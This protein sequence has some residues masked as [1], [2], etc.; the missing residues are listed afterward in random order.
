MIDG[1]FEWVRDEP[2]P[3]V[4]GIYRLDA[5]CIENLLIHEDAAVQLVIE[6]AA[7][8]EQEAQKRFDFG[9]WLASISGSLVELFVWFAVLNRVNP[10]EPT[11]GLGVGKIVSSAKKG[12]MPVL[13]LKKVKLLRNTIEKKAVD[14]VG[15]DVAYELY[16]DVS[17]RVAALS[18]P[19]DS[20]SGKDFLLPLFEYR[21][22]SC[23]RGRTRR[24]SL[25]IRLARHCD[26][27]RF[28]AVTTA[29]EKSV[30]MDF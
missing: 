18:R 15:R 14:A 16:R 28:V 21:L 13:D 27:S 26:R 10:T 2:P 17:S 4:P 11:I 30:R 25:R 9:T 3:D 29:L 22:W 1:D 20:V 24:Q 6:E 23:A 5:Y 7:V 19:Y 8:D 12:C